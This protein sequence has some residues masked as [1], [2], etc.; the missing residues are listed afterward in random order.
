M[1]AKTGP[2]AVTLKTALYDV[3]RSWTFLSLLGSKKSPSL[4]SFACSIF[5]FFKKSVLKN[6]PSRRSVFCEVT[7]G[8]GSSLMP[9]P[10]VG[11]L[12]PTPPCC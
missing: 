4:T 8:T 2:V 9:F 12:F 11:V 1:S 7:K 3:G 6:T 10:D 5:F